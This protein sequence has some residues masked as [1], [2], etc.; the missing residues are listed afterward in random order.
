VNLFITVNAATPV[1]TTI[2]WITEPGASTA[3][4]PII[5]PPTVEVK[6]QYGN[7]IEGVTVTMTVSGPG[8]FT[9]GSTVTGV[10]GINGQVSFT[11]LVLDTAGAYTFT[12]MAPDP[13]SSPLSSSIVVSPSTA[14]K[15][16]LTGCGSSINVGA[17][18]TLTATIEDQ[19]N[20][21]E[22]GDNATSVTF[23]QTSGSGSVTGLKAVVVHGGIA[24]DT[25]TGASA[26][27]VL[28]QATGESLTSGTVTI[29]VN[30]SGGGGGG[31]GTPPSV[32]I[33][34][35]P[36]SPTYGGTFNPTYTT[37]G[38]GTVFSVTSSTTTVCVVSGSSV[39]FVGVGL[40]TLTAHVASTSKSLAGNGS[41]QSFSVG[42]A[43]PTVSITNMP[44]K[45]TKGTHFNPTFATSGNGTVFTVVSTTASVCSVSGATVN[46]IGVGP[47]SLTV[48]VAATT[49]YTAASS[50]QTTISSNPSPPAPK[51]IGT[52][53]FAQDSCSINNPGAQDVIELAARTIVANGYTI[54]T[55]TGYTDNT[56]FPHE[57]MI[58]SAL[59]AA[60]VVAQLKADLAALHYTRAAVAGVGGGVSTASPNPA[61]DREAVITAS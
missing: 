31:G 15:I 28:V 34:N 22:T 44:V 45:A 21:T 29:T 39:D 40:C 23:A 46:F 2:V 32:S 17:T 43:V 38:N 54:V 41:P 8:T 7:P 36:P 4:S 27:P 48:T 11:N 33:T 30:S 5:G 12:A 52:V 37:S 24:S 6:D 50:T 25:V 47:C 13:I 57:N 20:N 1:A 49:D 10:T 18:C 51:T 35:I 26:G 56:G 42:K 59:R 58:L 53:Y 19:Y 9:A 61:L 55:V 3:G 14:Y 16:V 60:A